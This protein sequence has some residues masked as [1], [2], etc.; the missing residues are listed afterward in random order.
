MEQDIFTRIVTRAEELENRPK[1]DNFNDYLGTWVTNTG[2]DN[3][4]LNDVEDLLSIIDTVLN[5]SEE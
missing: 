4:K 1:H 3:R 5:Q 2:A